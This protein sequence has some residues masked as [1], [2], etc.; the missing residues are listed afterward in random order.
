MKQLIITSVASLLLLAVSFA[1]NGPTI[2]QERNIHFGAEGPQA[3]TVEFMAVS[4]RATLVTP[5]SV[6]T[7]TTVEISAIIFDF[8]TDGTLKELRISA[9]ETDSEGKI[10]GGEGYSVPVDK[11]P[12]A[13]TTLATELKRRALANYLSR[14]G[15]AAVV[16]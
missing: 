7:I 10:H 12:G 3:G 16:N 1:Q 2:R 15:Y 4:Q 14:K 13:V 9:I 8:N 11:L 5:R 6:G